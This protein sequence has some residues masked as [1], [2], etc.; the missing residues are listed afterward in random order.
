MWE[1]QQDPLRSE[2]LKAGEVLGIRAGVATGEVLAGNMGSAARMNYTVIGDD[3]NLASRLEGLN[4]Q[5]GTSVMVSEDTAE[6][7]ADYMAL[8]YAE[9]LVPSSEGSP[10]IDGRVVRIR[11]SGEA[12]AQ[13]MGLVTEDRRGSGIFPQL[14][15]TRN[16]VI[17][18]LGRY[19]GRWRTLQHARARAEAAR[20]NRQ[21]GTRSA[22]METPIGSLSG[23]NQQKVLIARWLM[24]DP[25]ILIMDEPTRGIDVGA[26][27]EIYSVMAELARQ[28]KSIIM[29]SSEM[30]ELIAMSH[31]VMVLCEG[32]HTGTLERAHA[33]Q[34]EIMRLATQYR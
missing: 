25:D 9:A 16:T 3:V 7:I 32:R 30:P 26:K 18:S 22:S 6:E 23:G 10:E 17:C 33:S 11:S 27:F 14:S 20:L 15:I 13:R 8:R 28:G 12:I 29:V 19:T 4:K 2:F 24:T 1:T 21:L 31:R 34:Q 5:W